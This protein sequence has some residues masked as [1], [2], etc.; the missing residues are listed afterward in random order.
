[1]TKIPISS[2]IETSLG[3]YFGSPT[4]HVE[5]SRLFALIAMIAFIGCT[6]TGGVFSVGDASNKGSQSKL[7]DADFK[8]M[9]I[10]HMGDGN[11]N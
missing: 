2:E 4:E 7:S 6:T 9:G 1:M 10:T 5:K 3:Y 11:S 8:R